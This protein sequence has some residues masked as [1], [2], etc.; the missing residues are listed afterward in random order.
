LKKVL[1][2]LVLLLAGC[3]STDVPTAS[4]EQRLRMCVNRDPTTFDPRKASDAVSTCLQFFV[5]EG[6]TRLNADHT[7]GLAGA[8]SV[9]LSKDRKTYTFHLHPGK[10]SDGSPLTAYDYEQSW[11]DTLDSSFPAPNAYLLYPIRNAEAA[12]KGQLPLDAVG[13]KALDA[14]TLRVELHTPTPYFLELVAFSAFFPINHA[15]TQNHPNWASRADDHFVCN[16]PFKLTYWKHN[17]QIV[18]EKNPHDRDPSQVKL[19][20]IEISIIDHEMTALHMYERGELDL[21]TPPLSPVP[22]DALCELAQKNLLHIRPAA[23]TTSCFFNTTC[24]PLN[25]VHIR[26]AFAYS[27]N[28]QAIVDTI[29]QLHEQIATG[30]IPAVLK[31]N[32]TT[33]FFQDHDI[34]SAR[35]H[36]QLG[37]EELQISA[38]DLDALVYSYAA[39]EANDKIAQALQQ[40]WKAALGVTV[41]LEKLDHKMLLEKLTQRKFVMAQSIWIAQYKDPMNILERFKHSSNIKNYAGWE[42]EHFQALLERSALEITPEER[43]KLLLRAES[44]FVDHMPVSPIFHWNSAAL[45]KPHLQDVAFSPMGGLFIERLSIQR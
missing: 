31:N 5:H 2:V 20:A 38:S 37:L 26:K 40:Q 32:Q 34:A 33:P 25:N 41:K 29:T 7:T 17:H 21:L 13:V 42:N 16:G 14:H 9:T 19:D 1:F 10:W 43:S 3:Q 18:L 44:L 24:F 36:L 23:G 8:K 11:K 39:T 30:P 35:T 28:R 12:K 45:V 27:M 15:V 22:L 4:A 6:L